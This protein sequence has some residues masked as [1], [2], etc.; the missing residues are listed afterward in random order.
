MSTLGA[1]ESIG[2]P[3]AQ[4]AHGQL[5]I[6][7]MRQAMAAKDLGL[8]PLAQKTGISK[9]RLGRILHPKLAERSPITMGEFR[10]LLE[11]LD[12]DLLQ[13][14]IKVESI[15]DRQVSADERYVALIAMLANLFKELPGSLIEALAEI[16]G[17]DGSEVRREWAP[18]LKT[19]VIKRMVQEVT[20]VM[21]RREQIFEDRYDL[22]G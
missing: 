15:R 20:D 6:D 22:R 9:S 11:A 7:L 19:V 21:R 8:R 1:I 3:V 16:D 13:A 10:V 4:E 2:G 14:I 18:R 5:Y 17:L 12:I